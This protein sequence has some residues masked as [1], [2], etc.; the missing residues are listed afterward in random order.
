MSLSH[1]MHR[2]SRGDGGESLAGHVVSADARLVAAISDQL[3]I[4]WARSHD[5]LES[6]RATLSRSTE[7]IAHSSDA[8][9]RSAALL[10]SVASRDTGERGAGPRCEGGSGL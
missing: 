7:L 5:R 1:W 8:L 2:L 6:V 4:T 10:A 9:A 3:I